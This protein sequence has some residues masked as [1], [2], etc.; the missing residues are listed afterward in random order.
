MTTAALQQAAAPAGRTEPAVNAA[1]GP[2]IHRHR[3]GAELRR[4]REARSLRLE[5][6]A[7]SLGVAAS[8]LSRI[9][10][11]K[12]PTRVSYLNAL[13][14]LYGV[15]DPGQC[16]E[17]A[18]L[19]R[20]GRRDS[21]WAPYSDVLPP[22]MNEYLGLEAAA[23]RLSVFATRIVPGLLQTAQYAAAACRAAEPGITDEDVSAR[24]TVLTRRQELL[25]SGLPVHV[26]L[27]EAALRR[28]VGSP[29]VMAAQLDHLAC[30]AARPA[31]N[32]QIARLD[33]PLEVLSPPFTL[34]D[35]GQSAGSAAAWRGGIDGHVT[36]S[37]RDRDLRAAGH[38]FT[39]L[40]RTA[41]TPAG[42]MSLIGELAAGGCA[43]RRA[44]PGPGAAP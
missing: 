36:V 12:A 9:E 41:L 31:L 16:R 28:Q 37:R 14:S 13:L 33:T 32:L 18:D 27:D 2:V 22:G 23:V 10:T 29:P 25:R 11:G 39:A 35:T 19:A 42:T 26:I 4:F 34:I 15:S 20:E 5:D 43:A 21:W 6:A 40:A 7:A 8:T 17:L 1:G 24:V 44:Q 3:L 38:R 30:L